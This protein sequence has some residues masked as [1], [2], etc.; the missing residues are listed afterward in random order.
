M[1]VLRQR[2]PLICLYFKLPYK[3]NPIKVLNK[4]KKKQKTKQKYEKQHLYL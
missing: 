2:Q 1:T 4:T 3:T